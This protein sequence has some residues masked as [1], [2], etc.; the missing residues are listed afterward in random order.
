MPFSLTKL[1]MSEA[2]VNPFDWCPD[3]PS[4]GPC[5]VHLY[6]WTD[7]GAGT[8]GAA[9]AAAPAALVVRGRTGAEKCPFLQDNS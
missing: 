4:F 1:L 5:Y 8:A 6:V 2:C 9:G 3:T 7:R